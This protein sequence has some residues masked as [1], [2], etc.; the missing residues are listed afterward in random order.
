MNE[1]VDKLIDLLQEETVIFI[2]MLG[3]LEQEN[4]A[5]L[6]SD[7]KL[8]DEVMKAKENEVLKIR[9]LEDQRGKL[10]K[11]IARRLGL[12]THAVSLPKIAERMGK[13][14][15]ET[16]MGLSEKLEE[17]LHGIKEM[18][19][20]NKKLVEHSLGL[21]KDSLLLLDNLLSPSPV[22]HQNGRFNQ[23]NQ[24]AGR[25]ICHSI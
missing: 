6:S 9:F 11:I 18:N 5:L 10:A 13:S 15:S 23:S 20:K 17:F 4:S 3:I 14:Y 12:N 16:L 2:G 25:L 19:L 21:V 24:H 22:Y 8:L 7:V 1:L